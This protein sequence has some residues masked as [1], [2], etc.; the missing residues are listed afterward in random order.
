MFADVDLRILTADYILLRATQIQ[1]HENWRA[2]YMAI[3]YHEMLGRFDNS[4]QDL[5]D[6]IQKI[7]CS[8]YDYVEDHDNCLR[9][10]LK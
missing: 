2:L 7:H 10:T 9:L 1:T 4:E 3:I 6:Y 5:N 8:T